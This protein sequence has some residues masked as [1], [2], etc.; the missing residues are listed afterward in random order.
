MTFERLIAADALAMV[1]A[2]ALLFAMSA[3]WYSSREGDEAR[4]I[5]RSTQ[6]EGG[7]GGQISREVEERAR[8]VGEREEKNA[9][10]VKDPID[11]VIL[12]ALLATVVL[13]LCAG[14][15][16]AAGRRFEPPWTASALAGT[17][18]ALSA[19]L[20]GYRMLDQPGLD[21]ATTVKSGV[22]VAL[23]LLGLLVVFC[24]RAVQAEEAG[25]AA[26]GG[27]AASPP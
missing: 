8:V 6:P 25:T 14:F 17:L 18:A 1:A 19:L 3:D 22:P 2:L 23:T 20:I 15:A 21:E 24:A 16:R 10:Q 27:A 9:W 12:G 11:R 26:P 13:A 4:R 7:A 5:E